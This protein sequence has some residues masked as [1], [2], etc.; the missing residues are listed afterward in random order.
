[1]LRTSSQFSS[2]PFL[3]LRGKG[4]GQGPL[5]LILPA[6]ALTALVSGACDWT[7]TRPFERNAPA[8]EQAIA[9]LDAGDAG[10]AAG[11]L[12]NYLQTGECTNAQ[13]GAPDRAKELTHASFDLGLA[14][15]HMAERYGLRFGEED[16]MRDGG[17]TPEQQTQAQLRSDQVE[18]ALRVLHAIAS[19]PGLPIDL[20][21]RAHYLEGNLEFLRGNYQA[22][23]AAYDEA[24]KL[25]PGVPADAGLDPIGRDAAWNRAIALRRIEEQNQRD[26]GKDGDDEKDAEQEQHAPDSGSPDGGEDGAKD[27]GP[28]DSPD[29]NKPDGGNEAQ[30]EGGGGGPDGGKEAGEDGKS[31]DNQGSRGDAGAPD[32][33]QQPPPQSMSQDERMLDLLEAA[34]TVQLQDAKNRA[35]RRR[36]SG[37]VD[38]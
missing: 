36:K 29:N 12:E 32:G 15:F 33:N 17:L 28:P 6:L 30:P 13:I 7:P 23:V 18:C 8:V 27:S 25:V 35:A 2:L 19:Q 10:A 34:P 38:K 16:V 37:M 24:L 1:M 21:A 5:A 9:Q 3:S 11:L 31:P 20:G 4:S 14:L 22:A 26:A